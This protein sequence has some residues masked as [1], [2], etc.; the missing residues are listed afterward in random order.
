VV[1][2]PGA[3]EEDR[4]V[5]DASPPLLQVSVER[6]ADVAVIRLAGELDCATAGQVDAA[7]NGVLD[8]DQPPRRILV[9][10]ERLSFIDVSGLDPLVRAAHRLPAG[11]SLQLRNAHRQV[12]RVIR[13]LDLGDRLGLDL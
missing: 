2:N 1:V 4:V 6:S 9:D 13:L 8:S 5:V 7:I 11:A 3:V 10:A 12:A